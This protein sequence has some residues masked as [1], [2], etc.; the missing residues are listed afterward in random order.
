MSEAI[1]SVMA[2]LRDGIYRCC[3]C[4]GCMLREKVPEFQLY[5]GKLLTSW[6]LRHLI[7]KMRMII[8][9]ISKSYIRIG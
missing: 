5:L 2:V 7:F 9:S 4:R 3:A 8:V 1:P 6:C